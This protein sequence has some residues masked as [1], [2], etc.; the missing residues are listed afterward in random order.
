MLQANQK[1]GTS[2]LKKACWYKCSVWC[3]YRKGRPRRT[4]LAAS[5]SF[6]SVPGMETRTTSRATIGRAWPPSWWWGVVVA[7]AICPCWQHSLLGRRREEDTL[8]VR[9]VADCQAV[10]LQTWSLSL[11]AYRR[12]LRGIE[13]G[14]DCNLSPSPDRSM[15]QGGLHVMATSRNPVEGTD[16][17]GHNG[18]TLSCHPPLQAP[19]L[20]N[21]PSAGDIEGGHRADGGICLHWGQLVFNPQVVVEEEGRMPWG[22]RTQ[23]RRPRERRESW[24]QPGNPEPLPHW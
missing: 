4:G 16:S 15:D 5:S 18:W 3:S 10:N 12:H 21:I 23:T 17:G 7:T 20:G 14:P 9:D 22:R 6:C 11:E 2:D 19:R 13:F 24:Q 8:P 1:W